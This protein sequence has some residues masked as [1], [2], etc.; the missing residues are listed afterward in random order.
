MKRRNP[1]RLGLRRLRKPTPKAIYRFRRRVKR[2]RVYLELYTFPSEAPHS[3]ALSRLFRRA[4]KLRQAYLH[5][6]WV[7][8]HA[9]EWRKAVKKEIRY[10]KRRFSKLYRKSVEDIRGVLAEW[11]KRFPPPW[12]EKESLVMW[13][14]QGQSW[15]QVHK[16]TLR[17]FPSP[18]Y[19]TKQLHELRT[20]IRKWELATVWVD[21]LERPPAELSTLL[22]EARDLY[23]LQKWLTQKGSKKPLLDSIRHELLRKESQAIALWQSWRASLG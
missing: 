5:E 14:K 7:R 11:R 8:L 9:P 18:P 6:E 21:L 20:L 19:T 2:L 3:P 23:L 16:A 10:R 1:F 12:K 13:E 22:G 17:Q 4:G 15:I